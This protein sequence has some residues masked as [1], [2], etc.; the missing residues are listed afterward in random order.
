MCPVLWVDG[1]VNGLFL[2]GLYMGISGMAVLGL[3]LCVIRGLYYTK[4]QFPRK[5]R[6]LFQ[7][8][9]HQMAPSVSVFVPCKGFSSDLLKNICAMLNQHYGPFNVYC[10]T[11]S[12]SDGAAPL[13]KWLAAKHPKMHHVV[14]GEARH[15][16]QKNHNLLA[17]IDYAGRR[18]KL[19]DIYA[20]AD[21]DGCPSP[22]WLRNMIL[23][24]LDKAVFAVSGFRSLVAET[25]GFSSN[26][27]AA[28]SA[29]QAMAM[30]DDRYCAMWGGS[31]ALTRKAFETRRVYEKWSRAIVD[32][33]SLS[34]II[35][36][37]HLKRV[38]RADC[39][40]CSSAPLTRLKHVLS[41]MVRQTQYGSVYLRFHTAAGL[42]MNTVLALV[43]LMT[44]LV[45]AL[46]FSGTVSLYFVLY[47]L[48][49]YGLTAFS[50]SLL[51]GFAQR[52]KTVNWR[53]FG[54]APFFLLLGTLCGWAGFAKKRMVWGDIHYRFNPRG[55][56]LSVRRGPF[57]E[58][59]K[60]GP[61]TVSREN[62]T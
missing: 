45:S 57:G 15:C 20:F 11:E 62:S 14:A 52:R 16:C 21:M 13:L 50:I 30:T 58:N 31:M 42:A 17:G 33:M 36:T 37:H 4:I 2:C 55:E 8:K 26:L 48:L 40:V 6:P 61:N 3:M 53:W 5:L 28:F 27:H 22:D 51:A 49:L 44:P 18:H 29:I 19:S 47:H 39:L 43:M 34:R 32:D 54:Y 10:I 12:E 7:S 56:V 1:M 35:K 25:P 41:W 23:P 59:M 46:L 9:A 60:N 24:L 38:F